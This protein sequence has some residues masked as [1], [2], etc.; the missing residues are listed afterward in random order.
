MARMTVT[1]GEDV[2]EVEHD[3]Q[4][5]TS[6]LP[7]PDPAW[8]AVDS[9]GHEHY[10][11]EGPDRYPTLRVVEGEP[12][13]CPDCRDE[14]TD[15]WWVCRECGEKIEPGTRVDMSPKWIAG[16]TTYTLNGER[17]SEERARQIIEERQAVSRAEAASAEEFTAAQRLRQALI[18]RGVPEREADALIASHARELTEGR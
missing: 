5:I 17:I 9:N 6:E 15:S 12:Y 3:G 13:W 18:S 11:Q 8:Q 4:W 14:H 16:P 1:D 7:Q 2:L 10:W